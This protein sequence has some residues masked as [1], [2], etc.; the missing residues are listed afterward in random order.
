LFHPVAMPYVAP[1]T[2][3]TAD[4]W[5]RIG[6]RP[7]GG[8]PVHEAIA[9]QLTSDSPDRFRLLLAFD[10][11]VQAVGRVVARCWP[12]GRL[13][14]WCPVLSEA[15]SEARQASI[16]ACL[17]EACIQLGREQGCTFVEVAVDEFAVARSVLCAVLD[18]F[19]FDIAAEMV[20]LER[21]ASTSPSPSAASRF[22][23]VP[24]T[25]LS[26]E[27]LERLFAKCEIGSLDRANA[28]RDKS[29]TRFADYLSPGSPSA[30]RALWRICQQGARP[31]GMVIPEALSG[32]TTGH[33]DYIGVVPQAR[34]QGV[35]AR[36][37]G[38]ALTVLSERHMGVVRSAVDRINVPSLKLHQSFG[39]APVFGT[40]VHHLTL[41]SELPPVF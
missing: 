37:L 17:I 34:R 23:V 10:D 6:T 33:I 22:S 39:F 38:S 15:L 26:A 12:S 4:L 8:D 14:F 1:L 19:R 2:L 3:D 9:E 16:V 40:A 18:T 35:G 32:Q 24:G 21:A 7:A 41:W 20:V 27:R 28:R 25:A 36:L 13:T 30:D 29:R 5:F 31:V 11:D